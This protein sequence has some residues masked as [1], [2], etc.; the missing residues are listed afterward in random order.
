MENRLAYLYSLKT[1]RAQYVLEYREEYKG[2]FAV[3]KPADR[4]DY[5]MNTGFAIANTKFAEVLANTPVYDFVGMDDDGKRNKNAR[6]LLWDYYWLTSNTDRHLA[7]VVMDAMKYGTG[8]AKE[9]IRRDYR[10][11]KIPKYSGPMAPITY[12]EQTVCEYDAPMLE[13][14]RWENVFLNGTNIDD[15]T[16]AAIVKHYDRDEFFALF[17]NNPMYCGVNDDRIPYGKR[18]YYSIMGTNKVNDE[19]LAIVRSNDTESTDDNNIVSVLEY[20]NKAKDQ[21]IVLANGEWINP[22][23]ENKNEVCPIPYEHHQIPIIV[24]TDYMLEDDIYGLGE[25]DITRNSRR[26][27]ND[28]RSLI[29]E[30]SEAMM[31]LIT[32]GET[33][34]FDESVLS[35]G[36]RSFARVNKEDIGFFAPNINTAGL[37]YLDGK[38]DEDLIIETGIDHRAQLLSPNETATKTDSRM[39][40]ARKRVNAHVKFNAYD[41]YERLARLRSSN[42]EMLHSEKAMEI[43][44]RGMDIDEDGTARY[45]D[46]FGTFTVLP[47][48]VKG[49]FN[50]IPVIDSMM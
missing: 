32:I 5:S 40:S 8:F 13:H 21:F 26:L 29:M 16:E 6:K 34:D 17:K 35:L 42:I 25:F 18:Y 47:K 23:G 11:L 22:I 20:Y 2:D 27:K 38:V 15:T 41:F 14:I 4:V 50:V 3:T 9:Y 36:S 45:V 28:N 24:Y 7:R 49:K 30:T 37:Q 19:S 43:F 44:V 1:H 10:T 33:A 39:Q 48:H 12:E 31:G 46:G